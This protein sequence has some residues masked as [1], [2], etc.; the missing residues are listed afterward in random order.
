M[1]AGLLCVCMNL[2][3]SLSLPLPPPPYTLAQDIVI[4]PEGNK[5]WLSTEDVLAKG[6]P[7][8]EVENF[9]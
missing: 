7:E 8:N 3:L 9:K 6:V 5:Y 1:D 4:T 2:S